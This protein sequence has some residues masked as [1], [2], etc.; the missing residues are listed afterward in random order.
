MKLLYINLLGWKKQQLKNDTWKIKWLKI[1][2][3]GVGWGG[4]VGG[5]DNWLHTS[6]VAVLSQDSTS[7]ANL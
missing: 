3:G 4:G 5:R 2:G 1:E 6:N 7:D